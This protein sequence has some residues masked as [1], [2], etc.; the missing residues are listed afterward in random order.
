M[1]RSAGSPAPNSM[2]PAPRKYLPQVLFFCVVALAV[3]YFGCLY[4]L[5][6]RGQ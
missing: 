5:T 2:A 6:I 1:T 4:L 3:L